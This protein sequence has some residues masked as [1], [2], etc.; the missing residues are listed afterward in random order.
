[1]YDSGARYYDPDL[2]YF[3]QPDT[4]VP[5]PGNVLDYNRYG[6]ARFNP[7][8]YNDPTGHQTDDL[9]DDDER[10][11]GSAATVK[12]SITGNANALDADVADAS[13]SPVAG[14]GRSPTVLQPSPTTSEPGGLTLEAA[15]HPE[16]IRGTTENDYGAWGVQQ[17]AKVFPFEPRQVEVELPGFA[18]TRRYD[19][20]IYLGAE[21]DEVMTSYVDVIY[22]EVK[23]SRSTTHPRIGVDSRIKEQIAF[24]AQLPTQPMWIFVGA[25]PTDGLIKLLDDARIV[26]H[27][28]V[29]EEYH[30]K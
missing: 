19:G 30:K 15:T 10:P 18:K 24:D 28:V 3:I 7:L 9:I 12:G 20:V 5:D 17:A 21:D 1:V 29:P 6:Y 26:W 23:T 14:A 2:G 27:M 22:V 25:R 16:Y 11:A 13:S 4:I 8:K